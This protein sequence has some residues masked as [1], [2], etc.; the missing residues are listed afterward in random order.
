MVGSGCDMMN[1]ILFEESLKL[2]TRECWSFIINKNLGN[3]CVTNIL[4]SAFVV[5]ADVVDG[6]ILKLGHSNMSSMCQKGT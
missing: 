4:R 3:P 1:T 5:A 6:T 2:N